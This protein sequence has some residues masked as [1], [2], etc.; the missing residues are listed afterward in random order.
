MI[1][2]AISR[3]LVWLIA[4]AAMILTF[5]TLAVIMCIRK[6]EFN[7]AVIVFPLIGILGFC[8]FIAIGIVDGKLSEKF[9]KSRQTKNEQIDE[10]SDISRKD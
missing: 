8:L 5:E 6:N 2:K 4:N 3:S 7:I 9:D 10:K 1:K